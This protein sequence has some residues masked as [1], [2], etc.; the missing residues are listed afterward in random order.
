[1]HETHRLCLVLGDQLSF[2]LASLNGLDSQR[3]A[4]LMVEVMEEASHVPHHPQKIALIFSAMRHF[5][6]ALRQRGVRVQYVSLDDPQNT[7]S[8]P[9]ELKRWYSQLHARELHLTECGDWRL[10]QSLKDCGL[11]IQWH[12]DSRFLCSRVEFVA[13]ASGKKQLRMEYFYREMRRKSGLLLNGDGTPVGGAWNFDSQNR[14][15]LPKG[16]KAPYPARFSSDSITRD[17]LALVGKHFSSHYGA[18]DTFDYPVTHADAQALWDY[19]LDYGL[20][21]FGDY[22]DAMASDEPF[23]FHA[24]ISAAL[25]IGLL[26]LRQLCSD[27]EAAYWSG[28]IGLNA[29]EGF[30]RQLIGW[31]EYVRGVYW[32]KMPDYAAGNSFGNSRPLPE[33]YWT[34]ETQMNCMRQA[35]GQSLKHA[36]AHHIQR[37]MVTGNFALLAGIVPSQICEWYLAIYMDAFDW[38]ELPNTL[39]MVMHADGGY[40]GSKP[41][42]ASG[43]YIKRMSDYCRGCAYSVTESTAENAC[44]FNSLYWHFLMRHGDLLR[45][46]QRMAMLYKN[47]D[48]MPESKQDALWKR[49][50]MLLARLDAGETL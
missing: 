43:Q 6:Q 17:V 21:G 44:P 25:N 36:Y 22:Q 20:A 19:F 49:G 27:V 32:L 13:W 12:A 3:D 41:Y 7:G 40:L 48:R 38:V 14:K 46:N 34:G 28:S 47:L 26:D 50:E 9:G 37:L 5:A 23:L 31:R 11:P 29:A 42:C 35:I 39:G 24:R 1:M 30:I 8:V 10:E 4:V 33:F 45:G 2:D 15:A 16:T 18:L